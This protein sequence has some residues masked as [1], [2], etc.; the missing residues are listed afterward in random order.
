M[1]GMM[2]GCMAPCH[3]RSRRRRHERPYIVVTTRG[4]MAVFAPV[5]AHVAAKA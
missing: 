3:F 4:M 2:N 5:P 1:Q